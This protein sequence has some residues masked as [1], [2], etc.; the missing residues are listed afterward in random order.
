MAASKESPVPGHR[1]GPRH[2]LA[3]LANRLTG[4]SDPKDVLKYEQ[5]DKIWKVSI[6][7]DR[8][9]DL[10]A[11]GG[12]KHDAGRNFLNLPKVQEAW[13]ELAAEPS[14]RHLRR[15]EWEAEKAQRPMGNSSG[16]RFTPFPENGK[17]RKAA[18]VAH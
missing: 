6:N 7:H 15:E 2:M 1:T 9:T 8:L 10:Q 11:T 12:S 5:V 18:E 4:C 17:R 14:R 13:K 3:V 16:K